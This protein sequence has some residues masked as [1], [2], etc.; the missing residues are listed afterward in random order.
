MD[1]TQHDDLV[2][3]HLRA[4]YHVVHYRSDDISV[5]RRLRT[6]DHRFDN[7]GGCRRQ[8]RHRRVYRQALQ[9]RFAD[10]RD[11]RS[12][13]R[14]N[15]ALRH[16]FGLGHNYLCALGV[17]FGTA[18]K[19]SYHGGRRHFHGRR[20][21]EYQSQLHGKS[22]FRHDLGC[23]YNELFPSLLGGKSRLPGLD[24]IGYRLGFDLYS[25]L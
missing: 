8:R 11:D 13:C 21:Q 19:R 7:L 10:R 12:S 25:F 2:Q 24:S 14:Q 1:Y 16:D 23:H 3:D 5:G 4:L 22:C 6:A 20:Q 17:Y 18:F 15:H 9:P